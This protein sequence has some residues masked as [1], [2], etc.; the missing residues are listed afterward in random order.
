MKRIINIAFYEYD[1]KTINLI[2]LV[3]MC[4]KAQSNNLFYVNINGDSEN[5][6]CIFSE[7]EMQDR[8]YELLNQI[9]NS[10]NGFR[11]IIDNTLENENIKY[12]IISL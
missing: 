6:L 4:E 3:S 1:K 5:V 8:T 10:D 11:M 9:Y 12:N 7:Y 2:E